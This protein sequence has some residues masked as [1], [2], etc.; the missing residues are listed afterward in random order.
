M[1]HSLYT[2]PKLFQI[3]TPST[4]RNYMFT[5]I[6]EATSTTSNSVQAYHSH[7][8]HLHS[9]DR[10]FNV[11]G[12]EAHILINEQ[13]MSGLP[14]VCLSLP[15]AQFGHTLPSVPLAFQ[16]CDAVCLSMYPITLNVALRCCSLSFLDRFVN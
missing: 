4:P 1:R 11:F 7:L 8:S 6:P 16:S 14:G 5:L 13:I 12:F 2:F 9:F 15:G 10:Q 3:R